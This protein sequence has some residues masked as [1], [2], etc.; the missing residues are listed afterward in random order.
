MNPPAGSGNLPYRV[1][2][3]ERIEEQ[4][5]KPARK[6]LDKHETEL[7]GNLGVFEELASIN[8]RLGWINVAMWTL[9]VAV[10]GAAITIALG[11]H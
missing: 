6:L 2:A 7:H 9:V 10:I 11:V 8:K 4:E 5:N 3:L 1:G